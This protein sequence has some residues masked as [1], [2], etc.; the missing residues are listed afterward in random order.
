VSPAIRSTTGKHWF[1]LFL[2]LVAHNHIC[3]AIACAILLRSRYV[4]CG[5]RPWGE[6][7]FLKPR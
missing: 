5:D 1:N 4:T 7:L 2:M 3:A 6:Y